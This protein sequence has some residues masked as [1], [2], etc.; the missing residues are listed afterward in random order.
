VD[1][2]D[3]QIGA[4]ISAANTGEVAQ[5][6]AAL[7][8]LSNAQARAFAEQMVTMHGAA[9]TRQAAL[10]QQK[11]ITPVENTTSM[12]LKQESDAIVAALNAASAADVDKLYIDKQVEVHTK[13]LGM[14][15]TVLIPSV[16]DA[17]LRAEL[18]AIREEVRS[19]LQQAQQIKSMFP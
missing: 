4:V 11:S 3:P 1:L 7:P 18:T 19:H 12:Q 16:D 2:T 5:A 9:Q 10:L 6:N 8:K 13:V 15:E 14:I 17:D